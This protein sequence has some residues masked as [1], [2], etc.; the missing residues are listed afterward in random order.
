MQIIQAG[1]DIWLGL[2]LLLAQEDAHV[3]LVQLNLAPDQVY[4]GG[5]G[6]LEKQKYG[7]VRK[8]FQMK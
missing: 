2:I 7:L 6:D 4:Q 8:A 5:V 1:D 3:R